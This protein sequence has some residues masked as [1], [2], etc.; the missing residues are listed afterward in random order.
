MNKS[1]SIVIPNYNGRNLLEKNLP[2]VFTACKASNSLFEVIISDDCSTDDSVS[3]IKKAY[4]EI[5]LIENKT[6]KGFSGNINTAIAK[7][8]NE[9][10]LLLNTDIILSPNYFNPLFHYFEDP[11]TFGVMGRIVAID[12]DEIQDTAKYPV[13]HFLS[14]IKATV[15]YI[16]LHPEAEKKGLPSLFLS[17]ANALVDR[18]KLLEIGAF[19]ELFNPFYWED[20]ELGIKAWRMNYF[21]YYEH[22]AICRH[23]ASA[24]IGKYHKKKKV[25]LIA[26]K[27]KIL[28]HYLHL[29]GV[30]L[31]LWILSYVIKALLRCCMVN[32]SYVNSF[33]LFLK[34]KKEASKEKERFLLLQQ[35][36]AISIGLWGACKRIKERIGKTEITKF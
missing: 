5:I 19:Q 7:A 35:N 31:F 3:F 1:L 13:F 30:P 36:N 20:V 12:S 4:P 27:N 8:K 16:S 9:L 18:K 34:Q 21:C 26:R 33:Y 14:G 17:G 25:S 28:F 2:S 11:V 15:N 10:V 32:F 29:K 6:N 24:T 23:P 22:T